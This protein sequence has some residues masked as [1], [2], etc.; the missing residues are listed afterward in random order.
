VDLVVVAGIALLA[1]L[2]AALVRRRAGGAA[3]IPSDA[4]N[5]HRAPGAATER[6]AL[7]LRPGAI[8]C[9]HGGEYVVERSLHFVQDDL[10]WAEHRLSD[11][12][13]G[14]SLSLEV[15]HEGSVVLTLFERLSESGS[16]PE[17]ETAEHDGTEFAFT[18]RGVAAYRTQERAG[19]GKRGEMTYVE[20]AAGPRRLSYC[21]FED[22]AWEI[23]RGTRIPLADLTVPSG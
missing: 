23:S 3:A 8:V 10:A 2:V 19:A 21:R 15:Q 18:E 6:E 16:P 11:N 20:F 17:G 7:S 14:R 22:G 1:I 4:A 12:R 13:S 5:G 9:L